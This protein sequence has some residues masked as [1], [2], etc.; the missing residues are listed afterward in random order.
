MIDRHKDDVGRRSVLSREQTDDQKYDVP[1]KGPRQKRGGN[2]RKLIPVVLIGAFGLLI[3]YKEIPAFA[4]WWDQAFFPRIWQAQN[5]CQQ[6]AIKQSN[7]PDYV[8]VLKPGKVHKTE[9]GAY[10][11]RLVL[12]EMD[13]DGA[14]QKVEYTCY[15]DSAGVLVK[16]NR[17]GKKRPVTSEN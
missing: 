11:D 13:Q 6:A 12:G 14:E 10:V 7:K 3:A 1:A 2:M 8:R 15:L 16:L 9:N 17:L 4:E 5:T